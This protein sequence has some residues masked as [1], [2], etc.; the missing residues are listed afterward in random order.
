MVRP[1]QRPQFTRACIF[2]NTPAKMTKEHVW[3][4]WLKQYLVMDK[5]NHHVFHHLILPNGSASQSVRKR[6]GSPL[7]STVPVVCGS[8]NHGWM[9]Q[10][11]NKAK[12]F[13]VPLIEGRNVG[14]G[15]DAQLSI[16]SWATMA[17]ITGEFMF[18]RH[19]SI[20][21]PYRD[22]S[23]LLLT[24]SPIPGWRIWIGHYHRRDWDGVFGHLSMP[25]H[26]KDEAV[27]PNVQDPSAPLSNTQW[28]HVAIGKLFVLAASSETSP[29][30]IAAWDWRNAPRAKSLLVQIWP[31]REQFIAWPPSI[32]T[33][34]DV[35]DFSSAQFRFIQDTHKSR[36][37]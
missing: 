7:L 31:T 29:D 37:G 16:A 14:L 27:I 13:L 5:N 25:I 15:H 9:S 23:S 30:W 19:A 20:A 26:A 1:I 24:K 36:R 10:I 18:A 35:V 32:M 3:G 8:C 34:R 28:S 11:Q 12:R 2:C 6:S 21:V 17:T 22:R 4:D 33:D